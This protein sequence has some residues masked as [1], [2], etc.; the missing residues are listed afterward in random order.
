MPAFDA[1]LTDAQIAALTSYLR[2]RFSTKPDWSDIPA[3][4]REVR[5]GRVGA[6]LSSDARQISATSH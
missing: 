4:L 2:S 5:D 6:N 1:I 3:Q